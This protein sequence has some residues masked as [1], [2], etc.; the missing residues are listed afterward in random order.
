L[1]VPGRRALHHNIK[2]L[3]QKKATE[4]WY[5]AVPIKNLTEGSDA[6]SACNVPV[7]EHAGIALMPGQPRADEWK[8]Q[9]ARDEVRSVLAKFRIQLKNYVR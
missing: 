5:R 9:N 3:L 8:K 2:A 4:K 1:H 6:R 7:S